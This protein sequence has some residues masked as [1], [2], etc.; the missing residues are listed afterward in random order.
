[1]K[2]DYLYINL[3]VVLLIFAFVFIGGCQT[4][5]NPEEVLEEATQ[6]ISQGENK[7]A[8]EILRPFIYHHRDNYR[9][10]FLM[11]Q[12]ILNTDVEN[13]KS[14]YI[15]R[16]Y[17]NK[18]RD[19]AENEFQRQQAD[20]AYADIKLLMGMGNQSGKIL[21]ETAERADRLGRKGQ[22]TLLCMQAAS[23]FIEETEYNNAREACKTGEKYAETQDQR[24]ELQIGMATAYFLENEYDECLKILKEFPKNFGPDRHITALDPNFLKNA[25][26][27][28]MMEGKRNILNPWKKRFDVDSGNLYVLKF[29]SILDYYKE[30]EFQ[31]DEQSTKLIAESWLTIAE[32]SKKNGMIDQSRQA[33]KLSRKLFVKAG[34]EEK[35]M[36]IGEKLENLDS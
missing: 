30:I 13:E 35:A 8:V 17:F 3:T 10:H 5:M 29:D 7:P 22:A 33:Y 24:I 19:L 6:L 16:Y 14:L 25:V 11:G 20:L 12:A 36:S 21:L 23:R 34:I 26:N 18:A 31:L 32:H 4:S 27:L 15:A 9:A 1:M 28:M 2:R